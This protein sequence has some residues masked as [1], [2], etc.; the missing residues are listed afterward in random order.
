MEAACTTLSLFC[1]S[2][3]KAVD[4]GNKGILHLDCDL[5]DL[6]EECIRTAR[7]M[8]PAVQSIA[9]A[10]TEERAAL[11]TIRDRIHT[12][13]ELVPIQVRMTVQNSANASRLASG[14]IRA[15]TAAVS[16][17]G[18]YLRTGRGTL[19]EHDEACEYQAFTACIRH[20]GTA[21][22][23]ARGRGLVVKSVQV[24]CTMAR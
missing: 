17:C 4:F 8:D 22:P 9:D 23:H 20:C 21:Q 14:M 12:T 24:T 6:V 2:I 7:D 5:A 16:A 18:P 13:E 15:S 1:V 11:E 10:L 3:C 19:H